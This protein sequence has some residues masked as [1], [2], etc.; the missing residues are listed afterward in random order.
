MGSDYKGLETHFH[1]STSAALDIETSDIRRPES[2]RDEIHET[3]SRIQF[4]GQ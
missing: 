4:I 2:S 1:L 3:D